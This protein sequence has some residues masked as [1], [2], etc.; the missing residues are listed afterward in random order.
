MFDGTLTCAVRADPNGPSEIKTFRS[1][2]GQ[3]IYHWIML[4][5]IPADIDSLKYI[6]RLSPSFMPCVENYSLG[7]PIKLVWLLLHNILE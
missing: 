6:P 3:N 5:P 7:L 1:G 4:V 2:K